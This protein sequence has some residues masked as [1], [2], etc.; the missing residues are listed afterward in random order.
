MNK[1][2]IEVGRVVISKAGRD[3]G[4]KFI[5]IRE[6][7]TDFVLVSDGALR[8]KDRPKKKRRKH[9]LPT[10]VLVDEL[11]A[12]IDGENPFQDHELR[13]WISKEEV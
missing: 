1:I 10:R 5:V 8:G 3:E 13:M 6:I 2:P 4:R 11:R 12:R 9:L 7:D